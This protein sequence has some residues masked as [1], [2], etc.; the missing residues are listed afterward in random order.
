[1]VEREDGPAEHLPALDGGELTAAQVRHVE[2][3]GAVAE[4]MAAARREVSIL[5]VRTRTLVRLGVDLRDPERMADYAADQLLDAVKGAVVAKC[6]CSGAQA[7]AA[8][9]LA[10]ELA[11]QL[12]VVLEE[13]DR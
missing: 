12:A 4:H 6:G 9:A 1:M 3:V 13:R 8:L 7:V 5:M 11:R 10:G 2:R